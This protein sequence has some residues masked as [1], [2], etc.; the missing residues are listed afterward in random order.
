MVAALSPHRDGGSSFYLHSPTSIHHVDAS[1][2]IRQLR[3]SLSRSPSK[4][5]DR[6]LQV[7]RSNSPS[8]TSMPF[9]PSPLSPRRTASEQSLVPPNLPPP[10]PLAVPFPPSARISRPSLRRNTPSQ[11]TNRIK[12]SPKSP[13]RRIFG[14]VGN[15]GMETIQ[16]SSRL[17]EEKELHTVLTTTDIDS[18][19]EN[20]IS[21]YQEPTPR[22][23]LPRSEKRHSGNFSSRFAAPSPLK[24]SD[25][26]MNMDQASRGSPSAKRRS[27]HGPTFSQADFNIFMAEMDAEEAKRSSEDGDSGH[28]TGGSVSSNHVSNIPKRSSS[29][30]RSTLQQRQQDR[31]TQ[32]TPKN[33]QR[34]SLDSFMPPPARESPFSFQGVLPNASIHPVGSQTSSQTQH[35]PHPLSRTMTQSSSNSSMG[36]EAPT[37]EP[38]HKPQRPQRPKSMF[39]FSKPD[40]SKSL[41]IGASRPSQDESSSIG[42]YGLSSQGSFATP[43]AFK[44]VKPPAAAFMSTG[45]ISK[46]NRNIDEPDGGLP[47]AH[48]PDTPCKRPNPVFAYSP[49][50]TGNASVAPRAPVY[51]FGSPASPFNPRQTLPKAVP[52]NLG[53][54]SAIFGSTADRTS[55]RRRVSFASIDGDDGPRSQSFHSP[56]TRTDSQSTDSDFPPTPTKTMPNTIGS[57]VATGF[58]NRNNGFSPPDPGRARTPH[59]GQD[60]ANSKLS[61]LW[62]SPGSN[63]EDGD[64]HM[65]DSPSATCRSEPSQTVVPQSSSLARSRLF[66]NLK[67]PTPISR[68]GIAA[69][70]FAQAPV[71]IR[72]KMLSLSPASPLQDRRERSSPHTPQE[73]LLPPDPSGLSISGH[74]ERTAVRHGSS[75]VTVP[76]ATP[77]GPREYFPAFGKRSSLALSGPGAPD[78][79]QSL[80]SR[81][82]KVEL[83][84]TGEFSQVYSVTQPPE[85]SPPRSVFSIAVSRSSSRNSLPER[86]WAVKKTKN[87]YNGYRDRRI[88]LREVDVLKALGQSEHIIL[89]VDSWEDNHHLYIQTE[90]C[91]EGSLDMFLS[92]VGI[93][94][95]LD[96]FRI[97]K[98]MLEMSLV[99]HQNNRRLDVLTCEQ[100][101]RHIHD[102]GFIHLDLKPAN[103][104][105][106][107]EG[108]LKI[109]DFGMATRW[110][111]QGAIEGEGD[112]EYIG[113]EVLQ[114][115]Y[116]KPADVFALGLIMLETAC[117]VMLPDNGDSWQRLRNGDMSD[118]PSLTWSSEDSNLPRDA[119]GN[120]LSS[121]GENQNATDCH[122]EFGSFTSSPE[123]P[124]PSRPSV[125][126][127]PTVRSGELLCPPDFMANM[128]NNES[129][130]AVVRWMISP[131][132]ADRPVASQVL[133]SEGI[134]WVESRRRAGATVF[135]GNWGPADEILAEDAEM[136]D[137]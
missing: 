18:D 137:V 40:F 98:I 17:K 91:E 63:D 15:R 78:V 48:M 100:G 53:K 76:P 88:K 127:A 97:W 82:E 42:G 86:V 93:K 16:S 14:D 68:K 37:P 136:M 56:I 130:D 71:A 60:F 7:N 84:G 124:D 112:R 34:M 70:P 74:H 31:T 95:R 13:S 80:T 109:A 25:G 96:D 6:R 85:K 30:R 117:N 119:S 55:L 73:N 77:T 52:L 47:K 65:E 122:F 79:D 108:T 103:V 89:F 90:F 49:I 135:E 115:Q 107:F 43:G 58:G 57:A 102:C 24:R 22:L 12:T 99:S 132:P 104:L 134:R 118:V 39:D 3:R 51:P 4:P 83:I 54:G 61:P 72:T 123:H 59:Y 10:S 23:V 126:P 81:F 131:N 110:P 67:S 29:L 9:S 101:I 75:S 21:E 125:K 116:D 133:Q 62:Q 94:A 33:R 64:S 11:P 128:E 106:T 111:A 26:I 41:P 35:F 38:F 2:A 66:R 120:P 87:P 44:S 92:Q 121:D 32:P 46:K 8:T 114:G 69:A 36:D 129:L 27:L 50:G 19:K 20:T 45:L 113:P 28:E 1:A 105:I 5:S